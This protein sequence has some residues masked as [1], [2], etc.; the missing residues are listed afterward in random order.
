MEEEEEKEEEVENRRKKWRR[1]KRRRLRRTRGRERGRERRGGGGGGRRGGGVPAIAAY[2][3]ALSPCPLDIPVWSRPA[4]T[5]QWCTSRCHTVTSAV[6]ATLEITV[7]P[8]PH[9]PNMIIIENRMRPRSSA[10]VEST[11]NGK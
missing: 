11:N 3:S 8:F 2:N 5:Q 4:R 9:P 6:L 1:K 7:V 10:S